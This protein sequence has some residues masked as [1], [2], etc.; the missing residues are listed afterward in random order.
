MASASYFL[1]HFC[2]KQCGVGEEISYQVSLLIIEYTR[3]SP[4]ADSLLKHQCIC[5]VVLTAGYSTSSCYN[6]GFSNLSSLVVYTFD[7]QSVCIP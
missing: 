5:E 2:G 1:H 7:V 3:L 6:E 4:D